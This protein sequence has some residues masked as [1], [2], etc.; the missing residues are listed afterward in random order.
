MSLSKKSE[1]REKSEIELLF[2]NAESKSK[3][4]AYKESEEN[5]LLSEIA[6]QKAESRRKRETQANIPD[7]Q[8]MRAQDKPHCQ[9][10]GHP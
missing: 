9:T 7:T 6:K 8:N 4:R 10:V 1:K 5:A 2:A 3:A